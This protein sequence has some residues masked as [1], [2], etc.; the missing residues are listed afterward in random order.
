M[1][2]KV[3]GSCPTR[4][5]ARRVLAGALSR[6]RLHGVVTNRD[7]LVAILRHEEF[8]AGAIDTGFLARHPPAELIPDVPPPA[9]HLLA[10]ALA[11]QAER[12]QATPV[13]RTFPSGWR[14]NPSG[15]QQA[16]FAGH[17]I[18][19]R[20]TGP[21]VRAEIGAEVLDVI[22]RAITPDEVDLESG[23]VRRII[24]VHRVGDVSYVDSVLGHSALAEE[25]RFADP[26]AALAAGSLVAPMPG[27]VVRVEAAAGDQVRAGQAIVSIEAM[28]MEHAISAPVAG[29]LAE[30]HVAVGDQ[31][32]AGT[33]VALL[34]RYGS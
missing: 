34:E 7:L 1:L 12:R 26:G 13:L 10:A 14:N 17:A 19:Y 31:I 20:I 9:L 25:A 15:M 22:A 24:S 4:D 33:V 27:T 3:I 11:G 18:G 16:R 21:A 5:D 28:K 32:D 29:V 8:A 2:A 6:A 23:G 30:V